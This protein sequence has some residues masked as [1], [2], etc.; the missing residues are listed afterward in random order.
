MNK[1]RALVIE[2]ESVAGVEMKLTY[3]VIAVIGY[4]NNSSVVE[5]DSL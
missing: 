5:M 4:P 2:S 3:D 1:W